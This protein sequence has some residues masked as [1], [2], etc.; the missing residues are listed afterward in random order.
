MK[1]IELKLNKKLAEQQEE[2]NKTIQD[3]NCKI[4]TDKLNFMKAKKEVF[5]NDK[6]K[7]NSLTCEKKDDTIKVSMFSKVMSYFKGE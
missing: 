6:N 7:T 2:S 4:M 5:I 1:I 3:I